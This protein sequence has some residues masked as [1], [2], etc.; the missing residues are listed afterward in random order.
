MEEEEREYLLGSQGC[1]P[2][3]THFCVVLQYFW[4]VPKE[5]ITVVTS[6]E[7]P[8]TKK[9]EGHLF[10]TLHCSFQLRFFVFCFLVFFFF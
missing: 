6:S 1:M 4:K 7:Y 10:F 2:P 3:P 8:G 9:E 5:W